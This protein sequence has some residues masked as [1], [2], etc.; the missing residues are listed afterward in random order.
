MKNWHCLLLVCAACGS[1]T[2]SSAGVDA[3]ADDGGIDP[4]LG[5]SKLEACLLDGGTLTELWV[6]NNQHGP[7]TS[8][9]ADSLVVLGGQDG[10]VKQWSIDGDEPTYGKPFTTAGSP[11]VALALSSD[12][13][14]LA[15]TQQGAVPAWRLSDASAADTM[16]IID[17]QLSALAVSPDATRVI[18]GTASGQ[19]FDATR[20]T[21]AK[22]PLESSLWGVDAIAFGAGDRL[23][24]AG[25]WY[26]TPQIDRRA[27]ADPVA[28][29]DVW[30]DKQRNGHVRAVA[31]DADARL[32]VAAGDGFVATFTP[33]ELAAGPR[34]ITDAADHTAVGAVLL[35]GGA[36]FVTAGSEGT[37]RVWSAETAESVTTLSVAEPIGLASDTDGTRLFTSGAD[38]KLHAFGCTK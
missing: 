5:V 2:G 10:S 29:P 34:A 6:V 25:H 21:G 33:D 11:V 22:T 27:A 35:P 36:L 32:L 9:V 1:D 13:H 12:A 15:A 17:A 7:V 20:A 26:G 3:G 28:A 24:T 37:L 4:P 18:V 31:T 14:V 23:F 16:T 8:I 19:L 30:N 38:G